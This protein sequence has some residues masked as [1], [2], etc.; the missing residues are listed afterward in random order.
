MKSKIIPIFC[1]IIILGILYGFEEKEPENGSVY[2]LN[3]KPEQDRAWQELAAIYTEKTKIPVTVVTAASKQYETMLMTEISKS[4]PPTLFQVDGPVGLRN[5]NHYCYD[6]KDTDFYKELTDDAYTLTQDGK[7]LSVAYVIEAYG[8]IVNKSLLNKAG[9]TI[10]DIKS[11]ENIK[12]I[13]ED[14]Y[15][16]K[17][18]LGFTA[19]TSAGMDDSSSWRYTTHLGNLPVYYEYIDD[20]I[21]TTDAIKGKY[22]PHFRR[23]FDLYINNSTCFARELTAKTMDDSRNEFLQR[24]AVFYQNGSWE[25]SNLIGENKFKEDELEMIPIYFGVNDEKQGL[26]SGTENYWCVNKKASP[27]KIKATIDFITWC[28]TSEEGT[29]AMA[30]KM[31]FV[32]PFKK[33]KEPTNLFIKHDIALTKSGRTPVAWSFTTMPSVLWKKEFASALA[34]YSVDQTEEKWKIVEEAFVKNWKSEYDLAN[35]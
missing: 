28:V 32:I 7:V 21:N 29:K 18:E 4:D 1:I 33:A 31:G 19:F 25:Y 17:E 27:K 6:L 15:K 24:K 9:Y 5:W 22:L 34:N 16:R 12:K 11:F 23:W 35:K 14:I 26:C 20:K 3:F 30:D 2:Y 8:L 13:A 10:K